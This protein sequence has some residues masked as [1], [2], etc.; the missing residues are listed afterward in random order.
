MSHKGP[1]TFALNLYVFLYK[2]NIKCHCTPCCGSKSDRLCG[3]RQWRTSQEP[4]TPV[5]D[6]QLM[7]RLRLGWDVS[8]WEG[9]RIRPGEENRGHTQTRMARFG[10]SHVVL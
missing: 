7:D 10:S 4:T 3:A 1:E 8:P 6:P 9:I 5:E 2:L